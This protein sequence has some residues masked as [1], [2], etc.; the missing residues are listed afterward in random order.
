MRIH[1]QKLLQQRGHQLNPHMV[2]TIVYEHESATFS[3]PTILDKNQGT[4]ILYLVC[5]AM[6]LRTVFVE[7]FTMEGGAYPNADNFDSVVNSIFDDKN[8]ISSFMKEIDE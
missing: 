4:V 6:Y 7:I 2:L 1:I 3:D 5:D 8:L